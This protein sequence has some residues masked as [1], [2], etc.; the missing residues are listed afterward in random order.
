LRIFQGFFRGF[1]QTFSNIIGNKFEIKDLI[2][3]K[4]LLLEDDVELCS[5]IQKALEQENHIVDCCNDGETA[6]LYAL[7]TEY[8]YDIA[9]VDRML[10]IIDGLTIIK[11]MREK[12]I[13]I[14]V[15]IIT[16][17]STLDNKIEGLDG[18]ADDYLVKPFH[19]KELLAR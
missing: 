19:I 3:M 13:R 5:S 6:L 15:I 8:A 7:N 10:P 16:G 12:G 2:K 17:M 4:I 18:G 1:L 11:A 14:P 9:I